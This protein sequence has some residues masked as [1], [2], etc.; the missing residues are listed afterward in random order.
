[1]TRLKIIALVVT[2]VLLLP[3]VLEGEGANDPVHLGSISDDGVTELD[4]A[5]D[6]KVVGPYAYVCAFNDNGVEILDISDPTNPTHVGAITDTGVTE[7]A[8]GHDIVVLGGYAYVTAFIDDG[9]EILDVS[10]PT[11][12]VHV[13]AITDNGTTELNGAAGLVVRGNLAY[14][15]ASVDNGVEILDISNP[16]NPTHVGAITDNGTTAL[17]GAHD[18]AI[19]GDYLFVA[20][21]VDDGIEVLDIS[22]PANPTHLAS[23]TDTGATALDG[24]EALSILLPGYGSGA[25]GARSPDG[26]V[27]LRDPMIGLAGF[28]DD[29]VTLLDGA[30]L[31]NLSALGSVFDDDVNLLDGA[32]SVAAQNNLLFAGANVDDGIQVIDISD[33][34]NPVPVGSINDSGPTELDGVH[35][36]VPAAVI[37]LT[38]PPTPPDFIFVCGAFDDDGVEIVVLPEG[39]VLDVEPRVADRGDGTIAYPPDDLRHQGFASIQDGLPPGSS[40]DIDILLDDNLC[41]VPACE[42][43][44]G[45]LGGFEHSFETQVNL[46]L[47][48]TGA[49]GGFNRELNLV[50]DAVIHTGPRT[51]GDP[52]QNFEA[53]WFV[54]SAD[55]AAD[56]DFASLDVTW[57]QD[58]GLPPSPGIVTLLGD[59]DGKF[60]VESFFDIAYKIDFVGAPGSPLDGLSGTTEGFSKLDA[61]SAL[62]FADGFESGDTTAWSNAVP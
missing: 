45:N 36:C 62:I 10:D 8:G 6:V 26:P 44:G 58:Q 40:I 49:L 60:V 19:L 56:P 2:L 28:H 27:E 24:V 43:L 14:I 20:S 4:G 5:T 22:N 48:G 57:G 38:Q 12:P 30:N 3:T 32:I 23:F 13:G 33:P 50:G 42:T 39:I 35:N 29:G 55:L 37:D 18:L 31:P 7:L 46:V 25:G 61:T 1:M 52:V 17:A 47:T 9:F 54:F 51:P 15:A 53:D 11:N 16:A 59:D 34:N 21:S 41:L